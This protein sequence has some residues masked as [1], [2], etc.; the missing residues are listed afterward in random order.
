MPRA[1]PTPPADSALTPPRIAY[2][3]PLPVSNAGGLGTITA[4]T[5]P[6]AEA[7]R[8]EIRACKK[9]TARP[10]GVN[11]TLLP[12]LAPPDYGSYAD[13]IIQEVRTTQ[14]EI[15]PRTLNTVGCIWRLAK[16]H[17]SSLARRSLAIER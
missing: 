7:L 13:V 12:A 16:C 5:Q 14:G 4:L 3:L 2:R 9:L 15:Q 11:L 6:D 17:A 10:F 1:P 8:R